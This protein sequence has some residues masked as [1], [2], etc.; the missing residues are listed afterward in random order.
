MVFTFKSRQ[1]D[2]WEFINSIAVGVYKFLLFLLFIN[3]A[4]FQFGVKQFPLL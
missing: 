4:G 1:F 2:K 3:S